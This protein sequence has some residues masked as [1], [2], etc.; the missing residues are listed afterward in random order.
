MLSQLQ[1]GCPFPLVIDKAFIVEDDIAA[2]KLE[3]EVHEMVSI[4]KLKGEW[5][6]FDKERF[7]F[8]LKLLNNFHK[9]FY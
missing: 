5:Y 8:L 7:D 2:H 1:V 3:Q 4:L 6:L 9:N